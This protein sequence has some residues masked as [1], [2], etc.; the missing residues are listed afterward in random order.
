MNTNGLHVRVE[1][2]MGTVVSVSVRTSR[3]ATAASDAAIALLREVD[4]RYSTYRSD[5][6]VRRFDRGAL[7]LADAP[8]LAE[9]L[10]RCAGLRASTDGAFD[11][12]ATG[13]LDPSAWVKGWAV[14]RIGA[15]LTDH[16]FDDWM[17]NAGGDVL[18]AA[19]IDAPS[20]RIGVQ[21]PADPDALATVLHARRLAVATSGAYLRGAHVV[22]PRTGAGAAGALSTTVCGPSLGVADALS[23]AAFVLG[24]DGPAMVVRHPGYEC[25]TA[26][27]D[28]RVV[29][30]AGFP[31]MVHGVPITV[32]RHPVV[33]G[34]AA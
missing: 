7:R 24:A 33:L 21:H 17:I 9:V 12:R 26:L 3:D 27:P 28:G 14:D 29:A 4:E 34:A 10:E 8:E 25:W 23:T 16:G 32:D 19:P 11:E 2:V 15:L 13:R 5:S 31:R 18:V 6:D 22:D 30:T 1:R 20:W